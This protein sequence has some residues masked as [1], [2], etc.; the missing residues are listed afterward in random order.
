MKLRAISLMA[1][2]TTLT[3]PAEA[4][5]IDGNK[6]AELCADSQDNPHSVGVCHG[7]V[8]AISDVLDRDHYK[9]T[10]GAEG[11]KDC[12]PAGASAKQLTKVVT[13]WLD[14]NPAKL[15]FNSQYLIYNAL[16]EG[17]DCDAGVSYVL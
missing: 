2:L 13:Q 17:F 8:M 14:E 3:L 11:G 15:H 7:Y 9:S 5:F 1:L 10:G 16:I 4:G 6:L 12:L